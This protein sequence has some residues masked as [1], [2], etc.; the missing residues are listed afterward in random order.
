[1]PTHILSMLDPPNNVLEHLHKTFAK[2][3]WSNKEEG[4][5]R[6]WT[7]WQNLCLPKEEGGVGFRSLIDV[8]KALFAKLW[9]RYRTTKSLWSNFMRNKYF[10]KELPTVV[11]FR[12][13]SHIWRKM[14]EAREKVEHEILWEMNRGSTNVWYENWTGLG[15]LYHVVPPEFSINE[16][17][18]EVAELRDDEDWNEKLLDQSFPQNIAN[19]IRQEVHFVDANDYWD[20]PRW[21]PTSSGKFTISSAWR[22]LRHRE[23]S[24]PKLAKLWTKLLPFK[25]SLNLA[26]LSCSPSDVAALKPGT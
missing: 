7:K 24:N 8:S 23:P 21:M 19:H 4:R 20:T 11:Q 1:M 3:F 15:A 18:Q 12:K 16:E 5:S 25:I 17:L 6:H 2:F 14:L 22:I 26:N 10:K 13:G 9:W